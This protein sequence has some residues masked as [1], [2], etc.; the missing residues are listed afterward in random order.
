MRAVF[1]DS[2]ERWRADASQCHRAGLPVGSTMT[3]FLC[4]Y[5]GSQPSTWVRI[6]V[7]AAGPAQRKALA[8]AEFLRRTAEH[9]VA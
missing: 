5:V 9:E 3:R 1:A 8:K 7:L 4:G 2:I 6:E